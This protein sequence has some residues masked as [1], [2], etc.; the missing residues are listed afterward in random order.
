LND[1]NQGFNKVSGIGTVHHLGYDFSHFLFITE[2]IR[3]NT[4][5]KN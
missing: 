2:L 5:G 3:Q 1:N 4:E